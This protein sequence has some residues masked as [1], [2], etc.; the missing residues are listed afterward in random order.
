[1]SSE[2]KIDFNVKYRNEKEIQ[3]EKMEFERDKHLYYESEQGKIDDEMVKRDSE[4]NMDIEKSK[5]KPST[6]IVK[7]ISEMK[8]RKFSN[9]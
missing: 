1:M 4:R 9:P 3:K 2:K 7:E 6:E 5:R 8:E